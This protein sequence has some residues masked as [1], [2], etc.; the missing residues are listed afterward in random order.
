MLWAPWDL[1]ISG[2]AVFCRF[3]TQCSCTGGSPGLDPVCCGQGVPDPQLPANGPQ[4]CVQ[5][6]VP[7]T[8]IV[9][10]HQD[11]ASL[12]ALKNATVPSKDAL[13]PGRYCPYLSLWLSSFVPSLFN[14]SPSH[15]FLCCNYSILLWISFKVS[16]GTFPVIY[17]GPSQ[18]FKLAVV[19]CM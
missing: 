17:P 13:S 14:V 1:T 12:Q 4:W 2:L 18:R 7:W 10:H 5:H 3:P 8:G 9:Q 11:M 19:T 16:W 6:P 15:S